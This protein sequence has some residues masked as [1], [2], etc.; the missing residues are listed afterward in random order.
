MNVLSN[1]MKVETN[2]IKTNGDDDVESNIAIFSRVDAAHDIDV[3]EPKKEKPLPSR[4][5]IIAQSP[6]HVQDREKPYKR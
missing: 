5:S 3:S 6:E 4:T 2:K 1:L